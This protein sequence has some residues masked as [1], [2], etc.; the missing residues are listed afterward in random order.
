MGVPVVTSGM[1]AGGVDAEP[2]RHFLA[3]DSPTEFAAAVLGLL[4][5]PAERARLADAG[6]ERVLSNHSWAA[7]LRASMWS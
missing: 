3:A 5:Q 2:G 7:S 1:A 6:R 4:E